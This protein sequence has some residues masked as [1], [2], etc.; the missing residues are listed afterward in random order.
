MYIQENKKYGFVYFGFC[1]CEKE[2]FEQRIVV[3]TD[4][5]GVSND[6]HLLLLVLDLLA[7]IFAVHQVITKRLIV[8]PCPWS[9]MT[10]NKYNVKYSFLSA[11]KKAFGRFLQPLK[12]ER[13]RQKIVSIYILVYVLV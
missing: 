2:I 4:L 10:K 3:A 13:K 9:Q 11:T 5:I 6:F 8:C 12:S 1:N 7:A